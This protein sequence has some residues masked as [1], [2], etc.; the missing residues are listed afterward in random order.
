M[1]YVLRKQPSPE[2]KARQEQEEKKKAADRE[3]RMI[4][5]LKPAWAQQEDRPERT[6]GDEQAPPVEHEQ[7]EP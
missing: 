3:L 1:A 5:G 7:P 4:A 2:E 6:E